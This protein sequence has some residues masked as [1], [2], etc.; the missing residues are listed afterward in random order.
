[1]SGNVRHGFTLLES[2]VALVLVGT[3]VAG[4]LSVIGAT[5]RGASLVTTHAR[6]VALADARMSALTLVPSDSIGY[7]ARPREG[8][9]APPFETYSWR[10]RLVPDRSSPALLRATVAVRWGD[11]EYTLATELFRRELIP[12]V[13]WRAR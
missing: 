4:T 2:L 8:T 12:G 11:G 5:L 10:A 13:R 9:F 3:V 6:A 7:Y 1:M